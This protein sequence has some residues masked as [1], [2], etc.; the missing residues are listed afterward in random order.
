MTAPIVRAESPP[1]QD[2]PPAIHSW[3]P[4]DDCLRL[5]PTGVD[6]ALLVRIVG[7]ERTEYAIIAWDPEAQA[8]AIH[9]NETGL[10]AYTM[11][12]RDAL[13]DEIYDAIDR[14]QSR[15]WLKYQEVVTRRNLAK[16]QE[17]T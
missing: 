11:R 8:H 15:T 9:W 17:E 14:W 13:D 1:D 4:K 2:A 10:R 7:D 16:R 6:S 3:G 12:K 5:E